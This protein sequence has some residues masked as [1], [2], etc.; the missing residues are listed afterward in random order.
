MTCSSGFYEPAACCVPVDLFYLN[1]TC[2]TILKSSLCSWVQ[3]GMHSP[4]AET[5][6]KKGV[7]KK[8]RKRE[9]EKIGIKT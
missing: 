8:E 4:Q 9:K 5:G 2:H 1:D 6:S 3:N 7:E